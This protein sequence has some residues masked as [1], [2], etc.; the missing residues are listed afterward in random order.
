MRDQSITTNQGIIITNMQSEQRKLEHKL[1]K[2]VYK[3]LEVPILYEIEDPGLLEGGDYIPHE[4]Y[5]FI[6]EGLRTNREAIDQLLDHNLF[7]K[8][9]II[10][11]KDKW[12][13][14]QQM[15]LDTFFNIL[16]KDTVLLAEN[17]INPTKDDMELY[18][19]IYETVNS[20]YVKQ[21]LEEYK[22]TDFLREHNFTIIPV[23]DSD[24]QK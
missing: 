19:D 6:C 11:V 2:L 8:K 10:V 13:N 18:V 9:Y 15:H 24:Q 21:N 1:I 4:H 20:S 3:I 22:F 5:D 12:K 16:S 7:E 14:Q 23:S 17:R